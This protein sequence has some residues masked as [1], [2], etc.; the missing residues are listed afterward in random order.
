MGRPVK[1]GES[2]CH[3]GGGAIPSSSGGALKPCS[4]HR[5]TVV[6]GNSDEG[7]LWR[8]ASRFDR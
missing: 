5:D 3:F 1:I 7:G 4:G 6:A 8:V 2:G